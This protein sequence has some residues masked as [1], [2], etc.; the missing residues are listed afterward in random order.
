M[1]AS[2]IRSLLL[3]TCL[4]ASTAA[5]AQAPATPSPADLSLGRDIAAKMLPNGTY[6]KLMGGMMSKMMTGMTDQMTTLPLRSFLRAAG[7]PES[8]AAKLNSVTIKQILD[9]VD[10]A[11][12]QR[13]N[14]LM[15]AMMQQMGEVM[16]QFE[17]QMRD[18]LAQ[19]YAT[20]FTAVQ[21]ADIDHFLNTPSGSAFAAQNMVI[22]ADPAVMQKMQSFVPTLMQAMPGIMQKAMAATANLPK[23]KTP[24]TLSDDDRARLT[25]LLG[26]DPSALKKAPTS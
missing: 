16:S 19:A 7:L 6:Q 20:H 4:L 10:P 21:L 5:V 12:Q 18:G 11:Y 14:V 3:S 24:A 13:M 26:V 15:P 2:M 9:I 8:D 17:P 23:P 25:K 22:A 1:G